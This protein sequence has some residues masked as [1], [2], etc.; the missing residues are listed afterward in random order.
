MSAKYEN[1][2]ETIGRTPIVRL[3]KLT[4]EGINLFVKIESFNPMGSV[5]DRLA[6]GVIEQAE[7]TG[8]LKPGQ[9]VIEATSNCKSPDCCSVFEEIHAESLGDAGRL[10]LA[11]DFDLDLAQEVKCA[12]PF[13]GLQD[14]SSSTNPAA[15]RNRGIEAYFVATEV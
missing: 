11:I 6:L 13:S 2:L 4:P 14:G 15:D 3:N 9:T 1:I 7:R 12:G 10:A 8:Q 5:K